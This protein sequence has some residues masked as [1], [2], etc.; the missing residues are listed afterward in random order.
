VAVFVVSIALGK[1]VGDLAEI[2]F[3]ALF[4]A[5]VLAIGVWDLS[6]PWDDE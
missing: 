1:W 6:R 5:M 4:I 3:L 2:I